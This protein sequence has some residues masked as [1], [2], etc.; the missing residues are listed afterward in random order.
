MPSEKV[1]ALAQPLV[2]P[3]KCIN[4]SM[5]IEAGMLPASSSHRIL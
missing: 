3:V 2:M 5:A 1:S 4:D